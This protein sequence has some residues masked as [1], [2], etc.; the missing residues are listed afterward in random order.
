MVGIVLRLVHNRSPTRL[1]LNSTNDNETT[2]TIDPKRP[3]GGGKDQVICLHRSNHGRAMKFEYDRRIRSQSFLFGL[4]RHPTAR[5][6]SEF[7]HFRVSVAGMAPT[8]VNFKSFLSEPRLE[9][10]YLRDM[11]VFNYT[12]QTTRQA[13]QAFLSKHNISNQNELETM[14]SVTNNSLQSLQMRRL[15]KEHMSFGSTPLTQVVQDILN[16]YDFVAVTERMDESLVAL[17]MLLNLTTNE[18]LYTRARSS[19]TFSNG[20]PK[21]PCVYIQPSFATPGMKEYLASP[22]WQHII[23]G[24]LLLYEAA[25]ASLDRT[26]EALGYDE[27]Q[28]N[29]QILKA[30]L[31]RAE[32]YCQGRVRTSCSDGGDRIPTTTCYIWDEGCDHECLDELV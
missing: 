14:I 12:T 8:D 25:Q 7:F 19:G 16:S 31:Q 18:I 15:Y 23:R 30:A 21:Q 9:H 6:V 26:I 5:A 17:Q 3:S 32:N 2:T 28:R 22:E 11:T 29:L 10:L 1:L 27:F 20:P 13:T 24:D 4:V